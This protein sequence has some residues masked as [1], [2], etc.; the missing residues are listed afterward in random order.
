M[1]DVINRERA[2][3]ASPIFIAD[4]HDGGPLHAVRLDIDTLEPSAAVK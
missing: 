4:V 3:H 2:C 1:I